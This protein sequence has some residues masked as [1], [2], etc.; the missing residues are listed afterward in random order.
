MAEVGRPTIMTEETIAKLEQAFLIG[1]SDREACLVANINP[2]TLYRYCE[3]NPEFSERKEILK[4]TPKYTAR[5]NIINALNDG[6]KDTSKWY[7]ERKIKEEF[8]QR[9]ET[10]GKDGKDII[11]P[12]DAV[13]LELAKK[14][15]EELKKG[16]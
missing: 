16:L 1:A 6:D 7:A 14:Y 13:A 4:D 12:V 9:T 11:I 15:E 5:T 10:T 2:A 3:E 8:A